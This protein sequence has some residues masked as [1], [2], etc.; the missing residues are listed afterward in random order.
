MTPQSSPIAEPAAPTLH[1]PLRIVVVDDHPLYRESL[2]RAL[3]AAGEDVVGEGA[4]GASALALIRDWRPDVALLDVRMPAGDGIEVVAELARSGPAVPVVLLSAFDDAPLVRAGMR[5]GAAAYVSKEADREVIIHALR[6]AAGPSRSPLALSR[7]SDPISLPDQTWASRLSED[8]H[9][10]L[11][12]AG[13]GL[14]DVA[15]LA[16]HTGLDG[17]HVRRGLDSAIAKLGSDSLSEAL[18]VAA[19]AGIIK[20]WPVRAHDD[21]THACAGA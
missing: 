11:R 15:D 1:E 19:A 3:R 21:A 9:W 10:L 7:A 4:D 8:E 20:R 17:V 18:D 12:L 16:D 6:S 2:V 13:A 5:A 14:T